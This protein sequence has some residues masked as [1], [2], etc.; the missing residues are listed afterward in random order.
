MVEY[1]CCFA[2]F[3]IKN[4]VFVDICEKI[5]FLQGP[6]VTSADCS[7]KLYHRGGGMSQGLSVSSQPVRK[8]YKMTL[9]RI[10]PCNPCVMSLRGQDSPLSTALRAPEVWWLVSLVSIWF[11]Y[12]FLR[13]DGFVFTGGFIITA[14]GISW[15]HYLQCT[16]HAFKPSH[17]YTTSYKNYSFVKCAVMVTTS[18]L[19]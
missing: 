9:Q 16:K 13:S 15:T 3:T 14:Y 7:Q 4:N 17:T 1:L 11:R 12:L 2:S 18:N 19:L 6:G 5:C 8:N 10:L